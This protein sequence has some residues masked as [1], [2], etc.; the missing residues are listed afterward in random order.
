MEHSERLNEILVDMTNYIEPTDD[1]VDNLLEQFRKI[2]SDENFRHSYY[3]ISQQ[4]EQFQ[5]DVRD[6]ICDIIDRIIKRMPKDESPVVV[7][8]MTKLYDHIKLEALRLA[9]MDMVSYLSRKAEE[10]LRQAQK[11]YADS[12]KNVNHLNRRVNGFHGQ[13]IAILGIFSGIVL[14]FSTEIK[15][16]AETFSNLNQMDLRNMLLYLLVIGFIAFN[17]LFMLM[18]A[19]SKIAD[20]S[21]AASCKGRECE[22][23]AE[24]HRAVGRLYR[25]YPYVLFFNI[26]T[27]IGMGIV[28]F[29]CKP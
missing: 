25:K 14:G 24:R 11:M 8:G 17:T 23:C 12:N 7:K 3:E 2:Y 29:V 13:S 10:N 22:S 6:N 20:Q 4:L 5:S 16:L 26:A 15:L 28:L 27:I 19:V 18:Y 9:R 21:I 1:E